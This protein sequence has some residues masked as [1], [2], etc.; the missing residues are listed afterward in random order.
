MCVLCPLIRNWARNEWKIGMKVKI[1]MATSISGWGQLLQSI[2]REFWCSHEKR[3][4]ST[5]EQTKERAKEEQNQSNDEVKLNFNFNSRKWTKKHNK[6]K[7][8]T[9]TMRRKNTLHV[10]QS[11]TTL[12][13]DWFD[14]VSWT[15]CSFQSWFFKLFNPINHFKSTTK[16]IY[17]CQIWV[18]LWLSFH[19]SVESSFKG[20]HWIFLLTQFLVF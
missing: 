7:K 10:F 9:I 16:K 15:D 13:F 19:S 14:E 6:V 8:D 12:L 5:E 18:I 4:I 20:F 1:G 11:I 2:Q 3:I 17:K